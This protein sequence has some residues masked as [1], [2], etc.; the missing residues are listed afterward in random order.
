VQ[1][2]PS[3]CF[4][5]AAFFFHPRW[6]RD[7][8]DEPDRRTRGWREQGRGRAHQQRRVG[9]YASSE[10][11]ALLGEAELHAETDLGVVGSLLHASVLELLHC[12]GELLPKPAGRGGSS[13]SGSSTSRRSSGEG[14]LIMMDL[15]QTLLPANDGSLRKHASRLLGCLARREHPD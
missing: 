3:R 6:F 1:R 11:V 5:H 7:G 2:W 10:L 13:L 9:I 8:R 14:D 12:A 15:V 4:T